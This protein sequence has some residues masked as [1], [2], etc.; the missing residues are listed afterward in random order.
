MSSTSTTI[1]Q[2]YI[3]TKHCKNEKS[4]NIR[5]TR[6]KSTQQGRTQDS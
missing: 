1:Y 3:K 6:P 5:M 4:Q 2:D